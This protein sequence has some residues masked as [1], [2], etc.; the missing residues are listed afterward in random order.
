MGNSSGDLAD[1]RL[2]VV[3]GMFAAI[4]SFASTNDVFAT[5]IREL[6]FA[7]AAHGGF[8]KLNQQGGVGNAAI[9]GRLA[10]DRLEVVVLT[11]MFAARTEQRR[12]AGGSVDELV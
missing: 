2:E 12:V 11:A 8:G 9:V 6:R 1:D 10:D 4:A 3:I 5:E 7:P